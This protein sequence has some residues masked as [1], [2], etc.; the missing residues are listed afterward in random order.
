M[1]IPVWNRASASETDLDI[2]MQNGMDMDGSIRDEQVVYGTARYT[3]TRY[4]DIDVRDVV[5]DLLERGI[6]ITSNDQVLDHAREM[7][8]ERDNYDFMDDIDYD[9]HDSYDIQDEGTYYN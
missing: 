1:T 6:E 8:Q 3:E 9:D 4:A 5:D 7:L 2:L